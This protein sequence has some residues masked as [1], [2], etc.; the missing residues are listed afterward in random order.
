MQVKIGLGFILA[1]AIVLAASSFFF[2]DRSEPDPRDVL[3]LPEPQ[4]VEPASK[5][6]PEDAESIAAERD[7]NEQTLD[8]EMNTTVADDDVEERESNLESV[9]MNLTQEMARRGYAQG[10]SECIEGQFR[11]N[12]G[13]ENPKDLDAMLLTCDNQ[14]KVEPQQRQQIREVVLQAIAKAQHQPEDVNK[15]SV[16]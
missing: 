2:R 4:Q 16:Q 13:I 8:G 10:L 14:F 7:I 15:T 9:F 1:L 5:T 12:Q 11:E 3:G 6:K